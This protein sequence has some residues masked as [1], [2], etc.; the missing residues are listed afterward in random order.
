MKKLWLVFVLLLLCGCTRPAVLEE[1]PA[2][3]LSAHPLGIQLYMEDVTPTG[4]TLVC[5]QSGGAP[6]G[7]LETGSPF[8]LEVKKDDTWQEAE[9]YELEFAWTAEAWLIQP[10][11]ETRWDVN[12]EFYY[13][14]LPCGTYRL[15]KEIRDFRGPGDYD[16]YAC[17]SEEFLID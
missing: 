13:G 2:E 8:W 11:A 1:T 16:E 17:Y 9:F 4:G 15:G 5:K 12:W 14:S 3:E 10:E 6:T 7:S